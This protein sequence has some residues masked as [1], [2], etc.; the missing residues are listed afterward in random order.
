MSLKNSR[1]SY[2]IIWSE[3]DRE[4][5]GLCTEFPSLS[6]VARTPEG[7]LRGIRKVVIQALFDS[8]RQNKPRLNRI[9]KRPVA[10][11]GKTYKTIRGARKHL[12]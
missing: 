6:W 10:E 11:R 8:Q 3:E 9:K 1:Y 7:A 2:R 5:V 4:Y 12:K